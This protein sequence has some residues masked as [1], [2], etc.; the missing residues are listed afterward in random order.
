MNAPFDFP[1]ETTSRAARTFVPAAPNPLRLTP[2]GCLPPW[3]VR[4]VQEHIE[5]NLS[6]RL[7]TQGL[8]RVVNLSASHFSRAFVRSFGSTVHHYVMHRRVA[9]A[10]R[11]MLGTSDELSRIALSC[12]MSDQSHLTRWFRRVVG[13]TPA[14]WRRARPHPMRDRYEDSGISPHPPT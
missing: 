11:L 9:L 1:Q 10:Q 3:Q 4:R 2:P 14:A 12:G 6:Q 7:T 5:A 8:A 13:E